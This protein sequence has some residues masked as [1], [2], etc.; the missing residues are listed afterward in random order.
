MYTRRI[1]F[2]CF[3][4]I[5]SLMFGACDQRANEPAAPTDL[6]S[7]VETHLD[8]TLTPSPLPLNPTPTITEIP[9]VEVHPVIFISWDG[10][11]AQLV[12]DLMAS[13]Q[14]PA[15]NRLAEV[16]LRAEYAQAIDPSLTA[17]C[18]NSISS[19]SLPARTGIVSNAYHNSNDNFYWYR[20]GFDEVM[21]DAEPVWVTASRAGLTTAALFFVGGSTDHPG[22][23]ADYTVSY[24]VRDAYSRQETLPLSPAEG[25]TDVPQSFSPPLETDYQI[26]QVARLSILVLDSTDDGVE[27]YDSVFFD[28]DRKVGEGTLQVGV[29]EWGSLII[30]PATFAGAD[31]L[32]QVLDAQKLTFYHTGVYHNTASPRYLLEALNRNFGYYP[33]GADSYALEH[34]W[35]TYDDYLYLM[36][37]ASTW[38]AEVTAWVYTTYQPDLLFTWQN[39]FDEAG[40]AFMLRDPR[41]SGYSPDQVLA[42]EEYYRRAAQISDRALEL[43]LAAIDIESSTVMLASDHGM[44]PVHTDVFVNTLLEKAG[45]LTLDDRNYVVVDE[46]QA[47]AVA[48]GGAVNVYINLEGREKNGIVS[49]DV[50]PQIRNQ[51]IELFTTLTDPNT[52]EPVFQRVLTHQELAPLGLDHPNS[53]DIFAQAYPGYNLNGWRGWSTIFDTPRFY[54]QHGYDSSSVNMQAMFITAG[55]GVAESG[56]VIPP[57]SVLDYAATIAAMMGFHPA[58][59]VDGVPIRGINYPGP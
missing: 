3:L 32:V 46:S 33:A 54:G 15:F 8:P 9:P 53:G 25:W 7:L 13:G 28:T 19:G 48:S 18:Q 16:G 1:W 10:A 20:L 5:F 4:L 51:I 43:M 14:L 22:Q 12:Y 49:E 41:Q 27:N 47:F 56:E 36:E 30:L 44:A 42:H 39:T 50:Y 21:D 55:Y 34:G 38:M 6:P 40:H 23:T 59:T 24:G 45:L 57:V 29:G 35:I 31:F 17:P 52:A 11:P 37:R 58:S 26:A 2:I